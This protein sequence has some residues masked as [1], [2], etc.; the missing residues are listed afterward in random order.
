[1]PAPIKAGLARIGGFIGGFSV[2]QRVL[3]VL[4]VA[5]L[6]VG[7]VALGAWLS[8]PAYTPLFSGLAGADANAV[9][10]QLRS[11]NVPYELADGGSTVLVPQEVVYE[12]RLKAAAAGLPSSS[13]GGYALLDEMGVTTSAFQQSVT[14]KRAIEGELARTIS[15][16]S[17]V[18]SAA[19]QLALPEE[20][21]FVEE[22]RDPTA[23]VFIETA[24]GT[25]LTTSQVEAIAHLTSAAVEGMKVEDVAIV[26]ADGNVLSALGTGPGGGNDTRAGDYETRVAASVQQ[27]LDRIVGGGNATVAVAATISDESAEVTSERFEAA[28][29]TPALNESVNTE[30]YTGTGGAQAGVLGPDNIAVPGGDGGDGTYTSEET[31][32]NN[33]VDKVT[34][35]RS[36]PA[37]AVARQ[38][39]SVAIDRAA[40]EGLRVAEVQDLVAAAAG[41]DPERGDEISVQLVD[42][43]TTDAQQATEALRAAEADAEA[44]RLAELVRWGILAAVVLVIG[45][46]GAIVMGRRFRAKREPLELEEAVPHYEQVFEPEPDPVALPSGPREPDPADA[47]RAEIARMAEQDPDRTAQLLRAMLDDRTPA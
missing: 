13:T 11:A 29:D 24:A 10:E 14:Y 17:G 1:M 44:E 9:V 30:E 43:S 40:A 18:K 12:E 34:E 47:K 4:A 23:S 3:A 7:V 28:A 36:I 39:V 32:R 26:D 21:V 27:M 25:T 16:M 8:R 22:Q 38:S 46:I 33:A 37:G 15:A 5:L 45:I 6:A 20:T 42:F 35:T 19:V 2:A 41:I 31:V